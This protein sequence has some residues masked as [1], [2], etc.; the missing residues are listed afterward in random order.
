VSSDFLQDRRKSLEEE[1]FHKESQKDL[2]TFKEKLAR[3]TSKQELKKAS[4]ME[5]DGVLDKLIELGIRAD[6]IAALSLVPLIKVAWADGSIQ[7]GEREGILHGAEGK[8]IDKQSG[9]YQLLEK[10]LETEPP[11]SL[12]EA[13]AAYVQ[14]LRAELT[15]E[16]GSILKNQVTRFA[17]IIA[18][19]AGGFLGIGRVSGE[20]K[21]ALAWIESV[22]DAAAG[23][24]SEAAGDASDES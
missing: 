19:S 14:T 10:W 20:E 15:P 18:E 3:Q 17:R 9:S 7:D 6:T 22:F 11:D 16:Q 24:E 23:D 13:W 1:F 5:D 2:A 4:G 21:Q 12:F 8:G